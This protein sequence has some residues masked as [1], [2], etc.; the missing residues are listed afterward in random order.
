M[1]KTKDMY[2]FS[3]NE[4]KPHTI[5]TI[6]AT[7]KLRNPITLSESLNNVKSLKN[8][9]AKIKTTYIT[10]ITAS[11]TTEN[12]FINKST[13]SYG[14]IVFYFFAARCQYINKNRPLFL[15]ECIIF[16]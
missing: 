8:I 4:K 2:F 16:Y 6:G 14:M 7:N 1:L 15:A 3:L 13:S 12:F 5:P 10:A 11:T 9:A